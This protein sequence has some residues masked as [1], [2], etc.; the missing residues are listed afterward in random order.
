MFTLVL[1]AHLDLA[2]TRFPDG[3][4]GVMLDGVTRVA[5]WRHGYNYGHGT[6]HGVGH[7]LNVHEMPRELF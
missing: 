2:T 3:T 6:G 5:M 1:K 7:F 4:Y